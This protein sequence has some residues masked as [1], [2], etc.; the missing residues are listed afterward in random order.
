MTKIG[1]QYLHPIT[2][3]SDTYKNSD[4]REKDFWKKEQKSW[5]DIIF[6]FEH[7]SSPPIPL[8]KSSEFS[9]KI[10]ISKD[11][12][13][14]SELPEKI[15]S[16]EEALIT[17]SHHI[18]SFLGLINF[19]GLFF[20]PF[21]EKEISHIE[22]KDRAISQVS[23]SGDP[24]SQTNL[25]RALHRYPKH[26]PYILG[27]PMIDFDWVGMR[28][29]KLSEINDASA[30]G[31]EIVSSEY[32]G[33][34]AQILALGAYKEYTL[35]NWNSALVLS[36]TFIEMLIDELWKKE[37]IENVSTEEIGRKK[38]LKD[39][40]TY[41]SAIKIEVLYIKSIIDIDTYVKLNQLRKLRNDFIHEGMVIA[42]S[43]INIFFEIVNI[44]IEI[45]TGKKPL[46]NYP[47]WTR[48]GGWI[49]K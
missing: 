47:G 22:L 12:L 4:F 17:L 31:K 28:I 25:K 2:F 26:I 29:K 15:T 35:H 13:I 39:Y 5:G 9:S 3:I 40:R 46:F 20:F 6:Q 36:W 11:G 44:I 7:S 33:R 41:S 18:N 34:D 19:G 38:R 21:S 14:A 1:G 10:L 43:D 8:F 49:E 16:D 30:L 32:F 42:E 45:T 48:S 37:M 24:Y 23:G 27:T